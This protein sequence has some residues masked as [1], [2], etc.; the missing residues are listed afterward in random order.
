VGLND[1]FNA[2]KDRINDHTLGVKKMAV[3]IIGKLANGMGDKA[4]K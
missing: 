1:I 4:V 2:L 3:E